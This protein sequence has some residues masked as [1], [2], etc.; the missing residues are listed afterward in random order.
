MTKT[1]EKVVIS[2]HFD[3]IQAL[4]KDPFIGIGWRRR[5]VVAA[6]KWLIKKL[7]PKADLCIAVSHGVKESL[8][9]LGVPEERIR[10]IYNPYP[11]E[12]IQQK[13]KEDVEEVFKSFPYLINVGRLT[14]PKGQWYLLRIF[15]S[16]KEEFPDLRLLILGEGELKGYLYNLCKTLGLRAYLWDKDKLSEDF[17]VYFLGFRENP[18][19]YISRAKLFLFPSI[20]EG[21][22]NVLV[23]ALACGVPVVSSD[24]RSGP[25]EILAPGSDYRHQTDKPEFAKYGVLMPVLDGSFLQDEPLTQEEMMW[26][27]VIKSM[28][29]DES[30]LKEYSERGMQ[31]AYDFH[32]EK[33]IKEWQEVIDEVLP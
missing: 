11:V 33:I 26:V 28:L 23:E 2:V 19:K 21:F 3:L 29:K 18:F 14:K 32:V 20:F 9:R 25:R 7:Y 6:Y 16:L 13:A 12:E 5:I 30:I 31:R 1:Q 15:R 27:E 10:V 22:G 4:E 17:D 24:C 8:V